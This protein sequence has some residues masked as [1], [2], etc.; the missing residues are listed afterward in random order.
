MTPEKGFHKT[1]LENLYDGVYYVDRDRRITY[2]N[3]SAERLTG[4]KKLEVVGRHCSDNILMHVDDEGT[5]LCHTACPLALAMEEGTSREAEVFLHHK[6]GHRVPVH[7]RAVPVR[8]DKGTVVGAVEVF[9]DDSKHREAKQKIEELEELALLDSLTEIGNRRYIE[10]NL[11]SSLY[12]LQRYGWPFGVLF[13][14]IDYFKEFNDLY[15]HSTGDEVLR[16]VAKTLQNNMRSFDFLGRW[17]GE[18]FMAVIV[19]VEE[20]GL[21]TIAHRL[22]HLIETSSLRKTNGDLRV[23]ISIGATAAH[24]E[25]TIDSITRRVDQLLY[26][27]KTAGRNRVAVD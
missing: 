4:F 26:E 19:N 5:I 23:T 10:M 16:M 18:E 11:Q 22:R 7:I 6:Q 17:G 25:D 13:I 27:T 15:G 3:E 24:P 2:W 21:M 9:S 20:E 8:D 12:E 14:D 1:I